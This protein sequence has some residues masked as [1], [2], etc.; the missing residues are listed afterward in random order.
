MITMIMMII[1]IIM[2]IVIMILITIR[3]A[4]GHD[5]GT[6]QNWAA[7]SPDGHEAENCANINRYKWQWWWFMMVIARG[8]KWNH[9]QTKGDKII[10]FF[11]QFCLFCPALVSG[12]MRIALWP[13]HLPASKT[14]VVK[15]C[16]KQR[17]KMLS[18]TKV[19]NFV[20]NKSGQFCQKLNFKL[21]PRL[22]VWHLSS[23][24]GSDQADR[25]IGLSDRDSLQV[26]LKSSSIIIL[27]KTSFWG[28][29][30]W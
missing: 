8:K 20:K 6:Y 2:I 30:S 3:W 14:K 10:Q 22:F 1:I 4:N 17:W 28:W 9:D 16:Q 29:K 23:F 25:W 11:L 13:C 18:T 7:G 19:E 27:V 15:F 5:L 21:I 26:L 12:T 24:S